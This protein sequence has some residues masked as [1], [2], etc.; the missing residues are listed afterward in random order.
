LEEEREPTP[1]ETEVMM[2]SWEVP[3]G[4]TDEETRAGTKDRGGEQH[5]A[6]KHHRQQKKWAQVN[7]GP[8]QKFAAFRGRFT[9]RAVP[10]LLKGHIHKGPR[11]NRRSGV[12][13]PGKTFRSRI[14]G[15]SLKQWQIKGNVVRETLKEQTCEKK[16]RT[17]PECNSGIRRLSK[18]SGNRREGRTEK[19]D[20]CL[21]AK[22][23][24]REIIRRSLRLEIARLIVESYIGLREPRDETLWKCRPP[25]KQ[26]R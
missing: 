11:R 15:R 25:P 24:H 23:M 4:G 14:D 2:E 16:R 13:G 8:R 7:G 20:Q 9:R 21:E 17:L 1:K 26:K 5:L 18:T 12:R 19:Q 3:K 10:A 22:M 6:V